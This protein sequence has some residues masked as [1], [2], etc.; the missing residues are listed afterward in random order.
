M[1]ITEAC[2]LSIPGQI[3][4][5][6]E[7][8]PEAVALECDGKVLT[9]GD[10]N[11]RANQV[12]AA[13][14]SMG[15]LKGTVVPVLLERGFEYVISA[16]GIMRAEA[17]YLPLDL[18]WPHN[19][20]RF[21]IENAGASAVVMSSTLHAQLELDLPF[22]DPTSNL[23]DFVA[24][25]NDSS[26]SV[27]PEQLAY[28][29][30]TS[31]STGKPKGVEITHANLS[32]L[33]R[34]HQAAFGVQDCDRASHLAG[35][36]FDAA[37][38][39]LWPNL[40]AGSTVCLAPEAVRFS[41]ADI[42]EWLLAQ[43]ITLAF[44]PTVHA[45]ALFS[46]EWPERTNLRFLLT[47][48]DAL[49]QLPKHRL[50]FGVVNN[51]G[52][53]ECTVVATS[54]VLASGCEETPTIGSAIAGAAI[55]IL[56]K[57]RQPVQD[58]ELGE[59][60][61]G[62]A[63]VGRGYRNLPTE[64]R[65]VFLP[66]P[67]RRDSSARM[68]KT[69]DLGVR[70]PGG[71]IMFHGRSDRQVK[72]RGFRIELDEIGR[73]LS[74][75]PQV[76]FATVTS[77]IS[78]TGEAE[79]VAYVLP[80]PEE[81][82]PTADALR[83]HLADHLPIY[84]VPSRLVQLKHTPLSANGKIDLKMLPAASDLAEFP[85]E[86]HNV[87]LNEVQKVLLSIMREVLNDPAFTAR[88]N[89]FLAG[90]HSL[91]GMQLVLRIRKHLNVSVSIRQLF[92]AP[93]VVQ[94]ALH[95]H[96][97]LDQLQLQ[98]IWSEVLGRAPG[99]LDDDFFQLGGDIKQIDDV[100]QRISKGT[101][102]V[103]LETF[104]QHPTVR[105]QAALLQ[106]SDKRDSSTPSGVF[107][108][109]T[110]GSRLRMFWI[111][112]PNPEFARAFDEE[113]P[114]FSLILTERDLQGLGTE[115]TLE[116]LAACFVRKIRAI[117]IHG[118]I[119]LGGFCVGGIL[120]FEVARQL[121]TTEIAVA[122]LVLLDSPNPNYFNTGQRHDLSMQRAQYVL[123]R[124][125]KIGARASLQKA[126]ERVFKRYHRLTTVVGHVADVDRVQEVVEHAAAAYHAGSYNGQTL[127]VVAA[128][129]SPDVNFEAGWRSLLHEALVVEYINHHHTELM[130]ADKLSSVV[131]VIGPY[132][133][134]HA[135]SSEFYQSAALS[136]TTQHV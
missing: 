75:H 111:H 96:E 121:R 46:M 112:Y 23:E 94:L 126:R 97:L 27:H 11:R 6:G 115:P 95:V 68:Y 90:G 51:Y 45:T 106:R 29:I 39:E 105:Q 53:T 92:E 85:S 37:V 77:N 12:A 24:A 5:Q 100:R 83:A 31:G 116:I 80:N 42:R 30:Y 4:L 13:L 60:Y 133:A 131:G 66:D 34:W 123:R 134:C 136:P 86:V 118:P 50:P 15:G 56:N 124:A 18:H 91:L 129:H 110:H 98:S 62:G 58:G 33:A 64:T 82:L 3:A 43:E 47:G 54:G 74:Q 36:G 21:A 22:L 28:V 61:I 2:A 44:V 113:Q 114:F 20:L 10:L 63:G 7:L 26:T 108:L 14:Q 87:A 93:T 25:Y 73:W 38:W 49:P 35:L 8:R 59:L 9:F 78:A 76:Q 32:H 40:S 72:V 132:L 120:A 71:E 55:Y 119:F 84:M 122:Q 117:Q 81:D 104:V 67:F 103:S 1:V 125:A 102:A 17:A 41:P 65:A 89:F 16:L 19:R 70:L 79:L 109:R 48:G 128:D 107:A 127:L 88:D 69:G 101:P 52:P 135:L 99:G 57:Q 130:S